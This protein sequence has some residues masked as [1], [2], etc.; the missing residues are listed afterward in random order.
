MPLPIAPG[1]TP[2][3]APPLMNQA[4]VRPA[5][6]RYSIQTMPPGGGPKARVL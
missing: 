6:Q 5:P 3:F 1:L 2:S 4:V